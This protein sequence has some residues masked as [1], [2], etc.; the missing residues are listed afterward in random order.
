MG[1]QLDGTVAL[2]TGASSGIGATTAEA[3]AGLGAA[4][5]A[6]AAAA[7]RRGSEGSGSAVYNATKHGVG[8]FS[9]ALRQEVTRRHVRVSLVEPGEVDTELVSHNLPAVQERHRERFAQTEKMQ[10]ADIAET[11]AFIITRPRRMSI[12]EVLVRPTEQDN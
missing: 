11:I 3:L 1:N 12:N 9:E 8:A 6:A 2:V 10:A 5:A 7:A 4:A